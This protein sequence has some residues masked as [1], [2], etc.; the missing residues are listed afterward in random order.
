MSPA[1]PAALG[2]IA[3]SSNCSSHGAYVALNCESKLRSDG[4]F[5]GANK[6]TTVCEMQQT[7]RNA[8]SIVAT[9]S[10]RNGSRCCV[11]VFP[12]DDGIVMFIRYGERETEGA[13][14]SNS[15]MRPHAAPLPF[16]ELAG[17]CQTKTTTALR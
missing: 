2:A 14:L 6:S 8:R 17:N 15:A 9:A 13:T 4:V 10:Q 16:N 3:A 1:A 11:G 12:S 7:E 5:R